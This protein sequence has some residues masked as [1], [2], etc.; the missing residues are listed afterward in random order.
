MRALA[1]WHDARL[2]LGPSEL[3]DRIVRERRVLEVAF[4]HGRPRDLW[5]RVRFVIDQARAFSEATGSRR[6]PAPAAVCATSCAGPTSRAPRAH[7]SSRRCSRRPTTTRCASSPSTAR[8]ASSSRSRSCPGMTTGVQHAPQRRAA[9]V[10]ARLRHLRAPRVDAGHHRGVRALPADRRADGLP[11]EAPA[12]LRRAHPR[13]RPPRRVGAPH[14]AQ[15]RSRRPSRSGPTPSCCG[16]RRAT[17]R[18]GPS[19]TPCST[20]CRPGADAPARADSVPGVATTGSRSATGALANGAAPRVW[21]ATA[22]AT[23]AAERAAPPTPAWPRTRATSSCRRGTRA[24]TAPRSG[25]RCT[26]CSRPS[27]SSPATA[28]T[29][30]PP[31]RP[32][33]RA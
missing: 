3:L 27:T 18:T 21:S 31:R 30:P 32:R 10:P 15:A 6:A 19:S 2:W 13:P 24:A 7:A 11:R 29:R 14:R 5:R 25:A 23:A 20:D 16:R 12:P 17:R 33:P 4:A 9:A 26:R 22:I 28:S 1:A 8:R